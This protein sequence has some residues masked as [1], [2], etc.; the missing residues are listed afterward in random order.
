MFTISHIVSNS[1]RSNKTVS[2]VTSLKNPKNSKVKRIPYLNFATH[3]N[4]TFEELTNDIV[5]EVESCVYVYPREYVSL[6]IT[7]PEGSETV[8]DPDT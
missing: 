1:I 5:G 4:N 2:V 8:H 7:S 6:V 3:I